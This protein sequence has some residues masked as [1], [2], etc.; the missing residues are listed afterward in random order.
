M[1]RLTKTRLKST[2]LLAVILT[3]GLVAGCDIPAWELRGAVEACKDKGGIYLID[4]K[5]G[6]ADFHCGDGGKVN[7]HRPDSN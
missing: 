1:K 7:I 5:I 2:T 4:P 3:V 6:M